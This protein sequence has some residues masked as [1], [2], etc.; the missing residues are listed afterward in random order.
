MQLYTQ[1]SSSSIKREKKRGENDV[2]KEYP[3]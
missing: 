3:P 2:E 1:P